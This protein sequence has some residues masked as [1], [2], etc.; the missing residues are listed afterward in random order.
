MKKP[1]VLSILPAVLILSGA[2]AQPHSRP[3]Q[4][5]PEQI[6]W[7]EMEIEMFIHFAPNTWQNRDYDDH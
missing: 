6:A 4:P 2:L 3:T 1:V 7:H 5:T